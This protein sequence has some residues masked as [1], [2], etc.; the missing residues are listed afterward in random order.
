MTPRTLA[1]SVPIKA[2]C[3]DAAGTLFRVR[4]SVGQVYTAVAARHGV[5]ADAQ[6]I[7]QRFRSAFRDMPPM[8][9]PSRPGGDLEANERAWWR[10]VVSSAFRGCAFDDFECFFRDLF[11]Y[12]ARPGS[13]ELFTD[14]LPTVRALRER[15][16]RLAIVSNF[17][18]RLTRICDGLQIA[19]CFDAII[20][21]SQVGYAKPD[22]R[23]FAVALE[24]LGVNAGEVLHVGDSETL[25]CMAARAAG[26]RALL[27]ER[28]AS[29]DRR[30]GRIRDLGEVLS[31]V[32]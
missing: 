12:F 4:G 22:P 27:I 24:R 21:S 8:C 29:G 17:D 10:R 18:S 5:L 25:D 13:W 26:V 31:I 28:T 14:A 19:S 20:A 3:F 15:H 16:L 32:S 1:P 23:I 11:D 30:E 7:E 6:T 9:F 2:V